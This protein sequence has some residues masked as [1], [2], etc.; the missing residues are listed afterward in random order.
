MYC[1]TFTW[2]SRDYKSGNIFDFTVDVANWRFSK[3]LIDSFIVISRNIPILIL[4][5][6]FNFYC[7]H[8]ILFCCVGRARWRR[9]GRMGRW[10][11]GSTVKRSMSKYNTHTVH[12][13]TVVICL[14][15]HIGLTVLKVKLLSSLRA[16][17]WYPFFGVVKSC[18]QLCF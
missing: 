17:I 7:I 5:Y 6:T 11:R 14:R 8:F 9:V 2:Q 16:F 10:D 18:L 1:V 3:S 15:N 4:F 12:I 13:L